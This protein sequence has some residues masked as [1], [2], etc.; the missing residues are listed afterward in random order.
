MLKKRKSTASDPIDIIV[1]WVDGNDPDWIK[2][3]NDTLGIKPTE[4]SNQNARYRDWDLMRYWFRGIEKYAPWVNTIH[5]VTWGHLPKWLNTTH[6][7]LNIVKHTS[8]MPKEA[9]PT[10]NSNALMINLHRID[11]LADR[12]IVFNDD[13]FLID[14]VTPDL[15]FKKGLPRTLAGHCPYRIDTQDPFF[16]PLNDTAIINKYF[17]MRKSVAKNFFKWINPSNGLNIIPT[18]LMLPFPAFYGFLNDHLPAAYLKKTFNE[19]WALENN[20]LTKTTLN[21]SR[22]PYDVNEWVMRYW[23]IANGSFYP[24]KKKNGYAFFP[25]RFS[26]A[27]DYAHKIQTFVCSQEKPMI[28]INDGD[29]SDKELAQVKALVANSFDR[30]LPNPS[31]FEI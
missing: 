23:Q 8:F 12:F 25:A 2:E 6:P 22:S 3:R 1:L 14:K 9:L 16:P 4:L 21:K 26:S 27:I 20:L 31:S 13:M 29:F 11:G 28:C 15:F 30:L 7:K 10:F 24:L 5:F 17:P 19:V 18:L